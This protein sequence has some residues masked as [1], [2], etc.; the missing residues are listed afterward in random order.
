M[1]LS[2]IQEYKS[3]RFHAW[4]GKVLETTGRV[5][6]WELQVNEMGFRASKKHPP[7]FYRTGHGRY[8]SCT[9]T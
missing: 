4:S 8:F 9:E 1:A 6:R 7:I 5:T 2:D 3:I